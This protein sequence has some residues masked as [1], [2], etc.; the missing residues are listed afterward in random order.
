MRFGLDAEDSGAAG[1]GRLH[2]VEDLSDAELL[3]LVEV[4]DVID[5]EATG[6]RRR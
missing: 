4:I 5:V 2:A 3:Q 6:R 1:R